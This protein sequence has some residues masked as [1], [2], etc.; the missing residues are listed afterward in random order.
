MV[1][2]KGKTAA[3][4]TTNRDPA[5]KAAL[6]YGPDAGLVRERATALAKSIVSDLKDPFNY[7]ELSDIDLKAEP[8]RLADEA[9]ALS[10]AGG[11]R[12]IRLRTVG[13]AAASPAKTLVDALDKGDLKANALVIIEGGD[14]GKTSK[15]RKLFEGSKSAVALPCYEDDIGDLRTLAETMA[16]QA[17]LSFSQDALDLAISLLGEDRGVSRAELEKLMLFAGPAKTEG[18]NSIISIAAVKACLVDT[19]SDAVDAVAGA[20]ADG[21]AARLA[22]NLQRSASAGASAIGL[23]RALQRMLARLQTA[24]KAVSAGASPAE[25]MKRLRPPVFYKEQRAFSDRLRRW[26]LSRLERANALLVETEL[27]AKTTGAPQKEI[28]ERAAFQIAGLAAR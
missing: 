14:L 26:P 5:V 23:L 6:I 1:A 12:V 4:F 18:D 20:A 25:A 8:S 17:G 2:L 24:Q 3:A 22:L 13:D 9:A 21:D 15:L 7:I 11:E 10:F 19:I 28:I 16:K 27:S